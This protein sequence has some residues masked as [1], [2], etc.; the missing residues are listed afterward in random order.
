MD[1]SLPE[2]LAERFRWVVTPARSSGEPGRFV[3]Y[4]MHNALRA[5]ENPALDVSICLARQNGLPLLVYHALSEDYPFASD[6]HHAFILQGARDVQRELSDRGISAFFHVQRDGH[7][8][9]H[10][11]T[12]ARD[13]AVLITEEMPTQPISGWIERLTQ[14]TDTPMACV[15][16][17][18][19]LPV[20]VLD[21]Q[22]TRAYKFREASK[23]H[24][25]HRIAR[26][27]EE[28]IVDCDRLSESLPFESVDLQNQCLAKLIETCRIDHAV[29]PVAETVGGTRA[30]YRR[31]ESFC[32]DG[33]DQYE[34][35]RNDASIRGGTSRM[36]AYLHYGMVS[37]FRIARDAMARD[38]KKFLDE[39]L[40]WRELSFHYC[41]HNADILDTTDALPEWA[42]S[43]LQSHDSDPR[44]LEL[45]WETLA[46]GKTGQPLWDACQRSLLK[47]GE[48]HNNVRM[49]WGK[50]LL[51]WSKSPGSALQL[52]RDLNHRYALDARDPCSYGGILWCFG[53]F[54]RPFEPEQPILGSVRDRSIEAHTQRIN[55]KKFVHL[56]DRPVAAKLPSVAIIGAGVGGLMAART[57]FDHGINVQIFEKSRG[58]GGRLATR[59]ID[60]QCWFD[61]GAQYFTARD[62][63][64]GKYVKSWIQDGIVDP[65]MGKIVELDPGGKIVA[66]KTGTPRY[67]GTP[68]MNRLAKHI[69]A[70]LPV[71]L[72]TRIHAIR[73]N[74][75]DKWE[76]VDEHH[77][78]VGTFDIVISNAPSGANVCIA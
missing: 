59:R 6:R 77:R 22:H 42:R 16:S 43:T 10:L 36:S 47:H 49:T 54:D 32:R 13:A 72:Q 30:G 27:Y 45:S 69:A 60:E 7:R 37:P 28:Q 3:L 66:D 38:A 71:H 9:A 56:V 62:C 46:R 67:V 57:L 31:W 11:R 53:Q 34:Q 21:Q 63:R 76:L 41:F 5:H 35:R 8:G 33:L 51:F 78:I 23:P 40:I 64:F 1:H 29:G 70:D 74:G 75:N 12:L 14:I 50:A 2:H 18:C 55:M 25:E 19:I 39:L 65:W 26:P 17:S 68:S 61:H 20:G 24:Y 15:D 52:V 44:P 73:R 4:W 48:L 58:V